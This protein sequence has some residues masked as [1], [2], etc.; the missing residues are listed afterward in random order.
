MTI[1]EVHK[2]LRKMRSLREKASRGEK[3]ELLS[4]LRRRAPP[5]S[6]LGWA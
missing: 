2:Y 4:K 5:T 1:D 6:C 3:G